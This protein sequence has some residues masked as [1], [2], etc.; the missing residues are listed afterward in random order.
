[1]TSTV[2]F[3]QK[4]TQTRVSSDVYYQTKYGWY[5]HGSAVKS[6]ERKRRFG[7]VFTPR[8]IVEKMLDEVPDVG[9]VEKT[10]FEPCCGE[11]AFITCVLRRK[12]ARAR[13]EAERVRACQTCYGLDIQLDNVEICRARMTAIAASHGVELDTAARIF[14]TNIIHGDMLFFPMIARFYDW[15]TGTWESLEQMGVRAG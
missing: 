6:D 9:N 13:T 11:G 1:M 15:K 5:D 4:S 8:W 10:V 14:C 3:C 7:E 2:G 12:L